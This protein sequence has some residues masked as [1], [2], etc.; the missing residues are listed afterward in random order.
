[1]L[2]GGWRLE[3]ETGKKLKMCNYEGK[4]ERQ[5][6]NKNLATLKKINKPRPKQPIKYKIKL[7][8]DQD[9]RKKQPMPTER[10]RE[11]YWHVK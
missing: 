3:K 9:T 7:K 10:N 4:Q 6:K 5:E 1:M 11:L 8:L 2:N